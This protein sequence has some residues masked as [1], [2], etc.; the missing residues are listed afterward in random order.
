VTEE[1]IRPLAEQFVRRGQAMFPD[2]VIPF[3][4]TDGEA[5]AQN[6]TANTGNGRISGEVR[7]DLLEQAL[8]GE[9]SIAYEPGDE[10]LAG[11]GSQWS[12]GSIRATL[13]IRRSNSTWRR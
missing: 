8:R 10:G 13:R 2:V 1:R 6:V 4:I 3:T 7:V 11:G 5:R 12:A 9:F